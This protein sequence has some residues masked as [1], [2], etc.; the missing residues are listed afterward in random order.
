MADALTRRAC[1][2]EVNKNI[3]I[4]SEQE[5]EHGD[6]PRYAPNLLSC[7]EQ[8]MIP[9]TVADSITTNYFCIHLLLLWW[10]LSNGQNLK[11]RAS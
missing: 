1:T 10:A 3:V 11:Q 2:A 7:S 6:G 8:A 5:E 4:N 9:I